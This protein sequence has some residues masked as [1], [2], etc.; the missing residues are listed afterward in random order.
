MIATDSKETAMNMLNVKKIQSYTTQ[1]EHDASVIRQGDML[2][3]YGTLRCH[4]N[5]GMG[6]HFR[7]SAMTPVLPYYRGLVAIPRIAMVANRSSAFPYAVVTHEE[8]HHIIAETYEVTEPVLPSLDDLM[9]TLDG[10]EGAP[11]FYHRSRVRT[12][13]GTD[14]WLY[15]VH[16]DMADVEDGIHESGDWSD[17]NPLRGV[18]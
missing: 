8:S 10:I 16:R 18:A 17:L 5:D 11:H 4:L 14:Y 12:V 1:R 6:G 7:A 15:T 3:V 2:C 13:E 9:A